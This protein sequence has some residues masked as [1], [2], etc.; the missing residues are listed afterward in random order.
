MSYCRIVI[1]PIVAVGLWLVL[2]GQSL[3]GEKGAGE[4][5]TKSQ[6][7][8]QM[9][10]TKTFTQAVKEFLQHLLASQL[11]TINPNGSPQVTVMWF[12]QEDGAV[13]FTTTTDRI[14][15]RNMQKDA[16]AVFNEWHG[17]S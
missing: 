16:R 11:T 4:K 15:F 14:K 9:D 7:S 17:K 6:V 5:F 8:R 2:I 3:A 10:M 13:L 1:V 12:Q